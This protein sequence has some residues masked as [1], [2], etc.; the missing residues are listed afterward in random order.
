MRGVCLPLHK[1]TCEE[2]LRKLNIHGCSGCWS[3]HYTSEP[4]MLNDIFQEKLSSISMTE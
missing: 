4:Q 1:M 3:F 2:C